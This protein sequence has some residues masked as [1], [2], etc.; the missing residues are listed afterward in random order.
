MLDFQQSPVPISTYVHPFTAF[1]IQ[2]VADANGWS[3]E[4]TVR[5]ALR[6]SIQKLA[7]RTAKQIDEQ[8]ESLRLVRIAIEE[9][10]SDLFFDPYEDIDSIDYEYFV[11]D[12]G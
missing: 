1:T 2:S 5:E 3:I 4:R 12:D 6:V 9:G 7:A 11:I 10:R 8:P